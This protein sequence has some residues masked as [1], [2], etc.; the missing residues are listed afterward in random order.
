VS[1]LPV[2]YPAD[3]P[4]ALLAVARSFGRLRRCEPAQA[5]VLR[6]AAEYDRDVLPRWQR[7]GEG[8]HEA[9]APAAYAGTLAWRSRAHWLDVVVPAAIA[10]RPELLAGV[11]G[12]TAWSVSPEKLLHYLRTVSLY[13]HAT[14]GRRCIVRPDRLA[15]LMEVTKPTVQRCQKAAE[16]LGL[17][18]VVTPGRMLTAE[19]TYRARAQGS[20]QRGLSNEAAL[21]VPAWLDKAAAWAAQPVP[22]GSN[23]TP[24][25]GGMRH[26]GILAVDGSFGPGSAGGEGGADSVG[27]ATTREGAA[28]G[29]AGR[30]TV[31]PQRRRRR[32]YDPGALELARSATE[33]IPWLQ[34]TP[35]GRIEPALRR[36]AS[37]RQPWTA[38]DLADAL[39]L[40]NKRLSRA[41]MTRD[42]V[43]HPAALLAAYL[44][45]LD[46]DADH[47]R[48]WDEP[49]AEVV[50]L[51]Q[52]RRR[53]AVELHRE[54]GGV[55][56]PASVVDL[57]GMFTAAKSS[58]SPDGS[59]DN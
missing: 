37:C 19:E 4:T 16:A 14:T 23:V 17:Y 30:P 47:P 18:V 33:A 32:S 42:R 20:R 7:G 22:S 55:Q 39:D 38:G 56:R 50:N 6:L 1:A 24:T 5:P 28:R 59:A 40:V 12:A 53:Q 49:G 34:G 29:V 46:P 15:E 26:P 41:S 45:D 27:P 31:A 21:V 58:S 25:S 54:H 48:A 44:R 3:S 8:V 51:A 11:Q 43:R 13:A 2:E 35:A 57:R 10:A 36:F 52:H 9:A